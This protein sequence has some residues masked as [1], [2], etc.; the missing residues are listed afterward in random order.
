M[1]SGRE[2]WNSLTKNLLISPF[3]E[4]HGHR[5]SPKHKVSGQLF[6]FSPLNMSRQLRSPNITG[7]PLTR[8][9][10]EEPKLSD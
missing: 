10:T 3:S 8:K 1:E 6:A 5:C 9:I 4:V 2:G 7:N